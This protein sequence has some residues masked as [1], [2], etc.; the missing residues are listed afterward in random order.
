MAAIVAA[1]TQSSSCFPIVDVICIHG[2]YLKTFCVL[3]S[4]PGIRGSGG[5]SYALSV[6]VAESLVLVRATLTTASNFEL[7]IVVN[8]WFMHVHISVTSPYIHLQ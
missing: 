8:E 7:I 2:F 5:T 1:P 3:R 6:V 4:L